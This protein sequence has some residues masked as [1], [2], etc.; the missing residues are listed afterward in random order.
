MTA[1]LALTAGLMETSFLSV[2]PLASTAAALRP[3]NGMHFSPLRLAVHVPYI[4][5]LSQIPT[6]A[7]SF[8]SKRGGSFWGATVECRRSLSRGIC[9]EGTFNLVGVKD[10]PRVPKGFIVVVEFKHLEKSSWH[11]KSLRLGMRPNKVAL[12][13]QMRLPWQLHQRGWVAVSAQALPGMVE[14]LGEEATREALLEGLIAS[15]GGLDGSLAHASSSS[16]IAWLKADDSG[17]CTTRLAMHQPEGQSS[18]R[19]MYSGGQAPQGEHFIVRDMAWHWLCSGC[20]IWGQ[21]TL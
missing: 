12:A 8:E 5:V 14:L 2:S 1:H 17:G 15:I 18:A 13:A 10:L 19:Y 11:C 20:Q 21:Q 9:K 6:P 16:L 4:A 3:P 7:N